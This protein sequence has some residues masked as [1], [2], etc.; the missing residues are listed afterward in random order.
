MAKLQDD[1]ALVTGAGSG[2]GKATALLL[3]E[4]GARV[5]AFDLNKE[6]AQATRDEIAA[7]GGAALAVAG[8]SSS[9]EQ[10]GEAVHEVVADFG[11]LTIL[12]N[13][14]GI[15]VRKGLLETSGEEW[16][17]VIDVNLNG[18]FYFLRA[19]VPHMQ[20]AGGGRIVQIASI[21]GHIG[22]GYPSYTAAK[23]GILA[24]TRQLAGELAPHRIR[25]N[26]VSPGVVET[27][28]NVD[29]LSQQSIREATIANTPWGRIGEPVDIARAVLFLVSPESDFITGS[30]L[31]VD[32][33]MISLIHWGKAQE[34]IQSFHAAGAR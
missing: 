10:V 32:G 13:A 24:L 33:G 16:R 3:A 12:V 19:S 25:I 2:L 8:D 29:T 7:A 34:S 6:A 17:R 5:A 11:K 20:E 30:D 15:V 9:E 22:Y 28:L 1:V 31:V 4:S 18:Y 26:S 21:A 27:G 14:A 23:G